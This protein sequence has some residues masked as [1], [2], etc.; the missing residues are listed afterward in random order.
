M[1]PV[2]SGL[3]LVALV[4]SFSGCAGG[5]SANARFTAPPIGAGRTEYE[6]QYLRLR[7]EPLKAASGTEPRS[8]LVAALVLENK[9]SVL[10]HVDATRSCLVD[11][12]RGAQNL[13]TVDR[14]VPPHGWLRIDDLP[15]SAGGPAKAA[16]QRMLLYF[17]WEDGVTATVDCSFSTKR[18]D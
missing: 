16:T 13:F 2:L 11:P 17:T 18:G 9:R 4:S 6:T 1:R 7:L 15:G 12:V 3:A 5:G 10:G 8:S 14:I